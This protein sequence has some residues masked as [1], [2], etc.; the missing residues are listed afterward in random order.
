MWLIS[1]VAEVTLANFHVI[2]ILISQ[3]VTTWW[4]SEWFFSTFNWSPSSYMCVISLSLSLSSVNWHYSFRFKHK[5]EDFKIGWAFSI[6]IS[7]YWPHAVI[8]NTENGRR[9]EGKGILIK[10]KG[11]KNYFK[12]NHRYIPITFQN[13]M[14]YLPLQIR[15]RKMML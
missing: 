4:G 7:I 3:T 10:K 14:K 6:S 13:A 11:F 2:K 8:F 9:L 5:K 1:I 15:I 12:N